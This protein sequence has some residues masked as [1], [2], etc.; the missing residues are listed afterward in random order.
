MYLLGLTG[1][2]GMGKTLTASLFEEEGVPRYDADAAVH[3]LYEKGGA[4]VAPI[5]ELVPAAI[6][7]GAVD[8]A[9]LGQAVLNDAALLKQLEAVVHPLAGAA[10]IAFLT[11]HEAAGAACVLLDIPLLFETGGDGFVDSVIVVSAPFEVQRERVLA[12]PGMSEEKFLAIVDKQLPDAEKRAR[13]EFI[14]D[15]S[16]SKADALRQVRD[17]LTAVKGRTGTAFAARLARAQQAQERAAQTPPE[18]D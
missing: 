15:S 12:R 16:I 11:H 1:S 14:V 5:G 3:K 2:I 9:V 8:R 10:Q 13:A 6:V 17:I 7:D 18:V 4:A